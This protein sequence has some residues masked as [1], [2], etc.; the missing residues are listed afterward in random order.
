MPKG[1]ST[2]LTFLM[3]GTTSDGVTT[4]SKI[5]PVKN[6][7]DIIGEK[8]PI[9]VTDLESQERQYIPGLASS[10]AMNFLA[11]YTTTDYSTVKALA[12]QELDLA[13][14]FGGTISG[15]TITPTGSD[16]KFAFKGYVDAYI[17]GKG[18]NDPRE[19]TIVVTKSSDT[20]VTLS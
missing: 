13:V 8:E 17:N 10:G 4:Y 5:C 15:S 6:Y 3:K 14:W 11:N 9:E 12:G 18:V 2:I 16:G 1:I 7:P 19:F 20:E